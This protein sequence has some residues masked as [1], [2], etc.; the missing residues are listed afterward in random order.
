VEVER[1]R[2]R[3]DWGVIH[4]PGRA[5]AADGEVF[6]LWINHGAAARA[7][8]YA[9]AVYP[10]STADSMPRPCET[11]AATVLELTDSAHAI[12]T[13]NGKRTLAAF[14]D[15]GRL[16]LEDGTFVEVD[17]PCLIMRDTA[18]LPNRLYVAEPTHR[19]T[20]LTVRIGCPDATAKEV[21]LDLPR[22]ERAGE[23]VHIPWSD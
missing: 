20:S 4:G 14:F 2:K 11:A 22:D 17:R 15:A 9:Y 16:S 18:S 1:A 12:S 10:D 8:A 6:S 3:G 23:T 5:G 21:R 7:A 19:E 13:R